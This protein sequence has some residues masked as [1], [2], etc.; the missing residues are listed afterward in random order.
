MELD[1]ISQPDLEQI[2]RIGSADVVVGL[3]DL[4]CPGESNTA[5]TMMHDALA[6]FSTPLRAMVMYGNAGTNGTTPEASAQIT[7]AGGSGAAATIAVMNTTTHTAFTPPPFLLYPSTFPLRGDGFAPGA[8]V[9]V[10]LDTDAGPQLGTAI[11]NKAGI[12]LGNF[13]L[14]STTTGPHKL[15]A[16]Q[17]TVQ[18]SENVN[19]AA[20]PK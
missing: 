2:E 8:T 13:T 7:V 11:P 9:T 6:E 16:V 4:S 1:A 18:A 12:F 19:L 15:V 10:H 14:P 3:L 5:V 20:Q 17:G